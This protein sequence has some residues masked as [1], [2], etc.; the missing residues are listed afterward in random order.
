WVEELQADGS[1]SA[2][3]PFVAR[4]PHGFDD[5]GGFLDSCRQDPLLSAVKLISEPWDCGPGG[6]QVGRFPPGWAEWNDRFRDG[7]RAFWKGD[8]GKLPEFA[9]RITASADLF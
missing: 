5:G 3:G 7:V 6:Y 9:A 4:E 2:L 8:E 1:A